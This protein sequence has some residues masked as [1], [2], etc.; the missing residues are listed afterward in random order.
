MIKQICEMKFNKLFNFTIFIS[1]TIKW[2]IF[3]KRKSPVKEIKH[4]VG[5]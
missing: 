3:L 2:M 1:F 4:T 5:L